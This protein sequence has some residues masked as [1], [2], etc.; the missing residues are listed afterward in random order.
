M[1]DQQLKFALTFIVLGTT[2]GW[3]SHSAYNKILLNNAE[4][5]IGD[6]QHPDKTS[7]STDKKI[8]PSIPAKSKPGKKQFVEFIE[9]AQFDRALLWYKKNDVNETNT[10]YPVLLAEIEQLNKQTNKQPLLQLLNVFLQE[11]YNNEQLLLLKANA[12]ASMAHYI[13]A[14]DV[15]FLAKNYASDNEHYMVINQSI[16]NFAQQ[17]FKQ[18]EEHKAWAQS[19]KFF[20]HLIE[21][22]PDYPFY[23]F[24]L[25]KSYIKTGRQDKAI[26][27]LQWLMDDSVY[28]AEAAEILQYLI[29]E[30]S[31]S[32]IPLEKIGEHYFVESTLSDEYTVKLLIDTGASY[33]SVSSYVIA[34]LIQDNLAEKIGT[35]LMYTASGQVEAD[36]YKLNKLTIGNYSVADITVVELNLN[37]AYHEQYNYDG[38]LGM[39]FLSQFEFSIDQNKQK[40]NLSPKSETGL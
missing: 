36:I 37:A 39:S 29:F 26:A 10:F 14:I 3:F 16:H 40:L 30:D 13:E 31:Q 5:S 24:S 20:E 22:E 15:Y 6:I 19:I 12:L 32:G 9:K 23:Y 21:N 35:Q 4:K 25:A 11:Y 27:H 8:K 7:I 38:L 1:P 34:Q 33:S 17:S 28:G 2:L 18:F